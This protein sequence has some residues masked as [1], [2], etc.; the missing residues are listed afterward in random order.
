[1][2]EADDVRLDIRMPQSLRRLI[3]QAAGKSDKTLSRWVREALESEA[4]RQLEENGQ[5]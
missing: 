4:R 5:S 1:M 3:R 2:A